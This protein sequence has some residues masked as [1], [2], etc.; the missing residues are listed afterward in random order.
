MM[1]LERAS[2]DRRSSV[3]VTPSCVR[4]DNMNG[5]AA[6]GDNNLGAFFSWSL[7]SH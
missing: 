7:I 2:Q 6:L 1:S 4:S 3:S 5:H